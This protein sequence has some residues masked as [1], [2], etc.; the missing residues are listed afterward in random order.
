MNV[1]SVPSTSSAQPPTAVAS[2]KV[3]R[4]GD[5]DGSTPASDAIEAAKAAAL[6]AAGIGRNVN[7]TA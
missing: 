2:S 7:A 3:D 5:T 1:S 6:Q 4:D